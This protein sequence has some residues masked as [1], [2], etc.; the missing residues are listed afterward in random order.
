M[1]LTWFAHQAPVIPLK[2]ARPRWFDGTALCVGSMMPDLMYS[3]S[4]YLGFDTHHWGPA[5][6]YGLPLTVLVVVLTRVAAPVVGN[7]LPDLGRV[8]LRSFAV[9]DRRW[10]GR[11]WPVAWTMIWSA[12]LGITSHIVLDSFTHSG[13]VGTRLLGYGDTRV[14]LFGR[15]PSIAGL[16]QWTGHTAGSLLGAVLV[17]RVSQRRSL[18]AWYGPLAVAAARSWTPSL[19]Q[20]TWFWAAV[21]AMGGAGFVWGWSGGYMERIQRTAAGLFTGA[22]VAAWA[23]RSAARRV[24]AEGVRGEAVHS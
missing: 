8:R 20:R 17:A 10:P 6:G 12:A 5:L 2:A 22:V 15:D 3:F 19:R 11:A 1:P 21:V 24:V 13:R 4:G 7:Q 14:H 16:V 18:E 9:L 23:M